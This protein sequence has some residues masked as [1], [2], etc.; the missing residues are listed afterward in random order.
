MWFALAA[1]VFMVVGRKLGW[2]FS[3]AFFY[4]APTFLSFRGAIL[5]GVSVGIAVSGLIGWLHPGTALRWILGFALGAYVAI[6]NFGL[7]NESTL[8]DSYLPR[9]VMIKSVPLLSYV[10]TEFATRSMR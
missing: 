10:V 6:P 8:P 1:L 4:P 5:W 3:K 7:F 2:L 9:H